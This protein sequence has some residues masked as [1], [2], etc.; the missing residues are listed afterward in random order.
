VRE[1]DE[2]AAKAEL[3]R[4][5]AARR[6]PAGPRAAAP[7]A[8]EPGLE[9]ARRVLSLPEV[10]GAARVAAF[11][12][13]PGEPSTLPLL[14]ALR[15]RGVK[16]LLPAVRED[17][18]LDFREYSGSLVPGALGTREPPPAAAVDL[19]TADAVL[20]PA[21]AVDALGR[22]LG[23]GGGSYDRALRRARHDA[24]LVAV[25]DDHALVAAVPVSAHD[26]SVS[27]I[28]TPTR[29]VRCPQV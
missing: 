7:G 14:D 17:L 10:A 1:Q 25:V 23:R 4:L 29:L 3:R 12:G 9:I 16:V 27:V 28:V 6:G 19:A 22:R 5:Q 26:L 8:T 13:L 15:S 20:I 2:A 24:A 18:D 11:V 21:V